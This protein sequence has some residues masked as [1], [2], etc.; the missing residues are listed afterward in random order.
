[1]KCVTTR[2]VIRDRPDSWDWNCG[3]SEDGGDDVD[4][5]S[6]DDEDS[7]I[8]DTINADTLLQDFCL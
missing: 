3:G 1:M 7:E 6:V 4:N 8:S 2:I 5:R